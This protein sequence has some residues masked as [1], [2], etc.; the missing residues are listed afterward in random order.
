MTTLTLLISFNSP[1]LHIISWVVE[2]RTPVLSFILIDNKG[3]DWS[4]CVQ[5][6]SGDPLCSFSPL[7]DVRARTHTHTRRIR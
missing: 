5:S 1:H 7:V 6:F 4:M 2:H 3:M